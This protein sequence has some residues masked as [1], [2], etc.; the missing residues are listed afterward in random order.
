MLKKISKKISTS[1]S[2]EVQID[3]AQHK[4]RNEFWNP[5]S[6]SL[7]DFTATSSDLESI[8]SN[9]V[10]K[11]TPSQYRHWWIKFLPIAHFKEIYHH[12]LMDDLP[13]HSLMWIKSQIS[14]RLHKLR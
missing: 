9:S 12:L 1:V 13:R 14:W 3:L 11:P 8:L 6:Q 5:A 2:R 7:R 4:I 10:P